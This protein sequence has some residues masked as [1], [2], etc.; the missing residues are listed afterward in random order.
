MSEI[1]LLIL[2]ILLIFILWVYGFMVFCKYT[3]TNFKYYGER[4]E[5]KNIDNLKISKI[6]ITSFECVSFIHSLHKYVIYNFSIIEIFNLKPN[7]Y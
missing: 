7:I 4:E 5:L 6:N 2:F 3:G 1:I